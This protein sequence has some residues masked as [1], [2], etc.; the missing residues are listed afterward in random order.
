[1]MDLESRTDRGI[2]DIDMMEKFH[3]G[4]QNNMHKTKRQSD[5]DTSFLEAT[6]ELTETVNRNAVESIIAQE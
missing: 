3:Q 2:I 5:H 6:R 4:V 1:M